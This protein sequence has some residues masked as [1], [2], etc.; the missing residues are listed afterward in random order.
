MNAMSGA[1]EKL[2]REFAAQLGAAGAV[3]AGFG[4]S[5]LM[6]ALA[7]VEARGGDVLVPDF[8]CAQVPEAVSRAGARP[9]FY[10]VRRDLTVM[11]AEF[12]SS[13]TPQTRAAI[14]AH[15][16]GRALPEIAELA[17]I[18]LQKRIPLI[19]DC[20]LALGASLDGRPAGTFGD[21]AV[22]S[23]TKSDWC[24]GGG[25]ATSARLELVDTMRATRAASFAVR[26]ALGL[27]YGLLRR[28]DFAANRPRF[29]RAAERTGRWLE[30]LT[31]LGNRTNGNFYDAGRFDAALPDFGARRALRILTELPAATER[32]RSFLRQLTE[33]LGAQS[34]MLFRTSRDPGDAASL[35]LLQC[36][37][38]DAESWVEQA[39]RESLT[40]RRVWPAYQPLESG[41]LEGDV[42][43]LAE[44]LLIMEI[45]PLL[46]VRESLHLA[47][48]LSSL[49]ASLV[50]RNS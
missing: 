44:R 8:I 3:A 6:L 18:C 26:R 45:H 32:R 30:R 31:E 2:E 25:I 35:L 19:E 1:V 15:Y 48:V 11:A 17:A 5:A 39:A 22:F 29:A 12:E 41:Q 23:F 46:L 9:V 10:R 24:Y 33:S 49:C 7:A 13:F 4:R 37:A 40:L 42:S 21:L 50:H 43:W 47:R 27:R 16:F 28:L 14:V 38:G 34:P 20:A 36:P